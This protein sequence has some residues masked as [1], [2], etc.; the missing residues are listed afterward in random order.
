MRWINF[1]DADGIKLQKKKKKT[2]IQISHF[3]RGPKG[4]SLSIS[5]NIRR[6]LVK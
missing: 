2:P 3:G 5:E 4:Q 6:N 1:K